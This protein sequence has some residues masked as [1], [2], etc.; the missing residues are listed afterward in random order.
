[1]VV[2]DVISIAISLL[3][4]FRGQSDGRQ[5]MNDAQPTRLDKRPEPSKLQI[6]QTKDCKLQTAAA[7][8][9]ISYT[10]LH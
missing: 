2:R 10:N 7:S 4:L 5:A 8:G 6:R 1:M 3:A 9:Q